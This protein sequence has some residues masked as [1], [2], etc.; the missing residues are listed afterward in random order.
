MPVDGRNKFDMT[1]MQVL[2]GKAVG[3]PPVWDDGWAEM[4]A[5]TPSVD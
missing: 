2:R 3:Q 4:A 1:K 5:I